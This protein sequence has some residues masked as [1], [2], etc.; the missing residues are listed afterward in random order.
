[1]EDKEVSAKKNC[2]LS[3]TELRVEDL[4]KDKR[5][6]AMAVNNYIQNLIREAKKRVRKMA[7]ENALIS[8]GLLFI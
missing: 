3:Y 7:A 6:T 2:I 1:M 4:Y 5:S 8:K